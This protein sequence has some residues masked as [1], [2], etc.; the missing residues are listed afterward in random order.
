MYTIGTRARV[1]LRTDG[2]QHVRGGR[3]TSVRARRARNCTCSGHHWWGPEPRAPAEESALWSG[4]EPQKSSGTSPEMDQRVV[5]AIQSG[6]SGTA[7][8]AH[9]AVAASGKLR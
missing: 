6:K 7:A 3:Y 1:D 5:W 9:S 4:T 8:K 2:Y